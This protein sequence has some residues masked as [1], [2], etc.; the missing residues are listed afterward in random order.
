M[1]QGR[2]SRAAAAEAG[3]NDRTAEQIAAANK[4]AAASRKAAAQAAA[5][6]MGATK[7]SNWSKTIDKAF[8]IAQGSAKTS[9]S[10]STSQKTGTTA[11][12]GA[13][14]VRAQYLVPSDD[15]GKPPTTKTFTGSTQAW[16]KLKTTLGLTGSSILG[17]DQKGGGS[18]GGGSST[19]KTTSTSGAKGSRTAAVAYLQQQA[20]IQGR[21][22][23]K[24]QASGMVDAWLGS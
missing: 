1:E 9:S 5:T 22:L 18:S 2:Q 20:R 3:R 13:G 14:Q 23:T 21:T 11:S 6:K 24:A 12:S 15:P 8:E 19:T 7:D 10:S 17:V 16:Q 4:R